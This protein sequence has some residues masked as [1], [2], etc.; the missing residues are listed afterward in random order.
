MTLL[1]AAGI[2]A[3]LVVA[4][5]ALNSWLLDR[6]HRQWMRDQKAYRDRCF[7]ADPDLE[8]E[9]GSRWV[10]WKSRPYCTPLSRAGP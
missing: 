9:R 6:G 1:I 7:D 4:V 8:G 3:T 10:Y 2:V 5:V